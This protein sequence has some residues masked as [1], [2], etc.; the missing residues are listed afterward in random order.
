[1]AV[2]EYRRPVLFSKPVSFFSYRLEGLTRRTIN[3]MLSRSEIR[4]WVPVS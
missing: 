4:F 2:I 1:M 3:R